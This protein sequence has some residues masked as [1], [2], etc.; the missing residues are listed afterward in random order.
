MNN[1]FFR[2]VS[3]L[4]DCD[5]ATG[6]SLEED[7]FSLSSTSTTNSACENKSLPSNSTENSKS[8]SLSRQTLQTC[9]FNTTCKY[10]SFIKSF[11]RI[12]VVV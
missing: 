6:N 12:S 2:T 4:S 10:I 7:D 11:K 8:R 5:K 3:N 1:I 9:T